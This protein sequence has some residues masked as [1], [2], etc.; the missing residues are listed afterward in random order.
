MKFFP[1]CTVV[2]KTKKLVEIREVWWYMPLNQAEGRKRQAD[3]CE[4][5]TN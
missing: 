3:L 4:M 2:I 1:F 5:E